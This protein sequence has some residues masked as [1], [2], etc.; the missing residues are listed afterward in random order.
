M[1]KSEVS[2]ENALA[3]ITNVQRFSTE[4][5]PGIRTTVFFKG[6]PLS[7]PWCHNPEG[8]LKEPELAFTQSR[9]IG[10]GECE[11]VCPVGAPIPGGPESPKD[12]K[13]SECRRCFACVSVCPSTARE[14]MGREYTVEE[15]FSELLRDKVF[16][17]KSG[18]GVTVSGGEPMLWH[19]FLAFLFK[20]L[21]EAG[22]HTALDTSAVIG[23]D[24]LAKVLAHT[25]LALVDLKIMDEE[26]H[27]EIIGAELPRILENISQ[28]DR[29]NVPII[30]RVP[31][32][33]GYTDDEAN[34]HKMAEFARGLKNLSSV[35]LL[36]FHQLGQSKY[37]KL[38]K[39]YA[40]SHLAPP[41]PEKMQA[42]AEILNQH[43]IEKV[44][45]K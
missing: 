5:G 29:A 37:K 18:G 32:V 24:A 20:R 40:L 45:I 43:G 7:C 12:L 14:K 13:D 4:D 19:E 21:R 15:L 2:G 6:C 30:I 39:P 42:L 9:C 22:L 44:I 27:R 38:G 31:V 11:K 16:Y 36:A 8:L 10:C 41:G 23:G 25:S 26:K 33:P 17:E 1:S 28:I 34:I 35:E 3:L